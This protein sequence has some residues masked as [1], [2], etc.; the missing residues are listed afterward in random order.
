MRKYTLKQI[1]DF[2]R[3]GL[4][5][6]ISNY[7]NREMRDFMKAHRLEK[8]GY[9]AGINGINGGLLQDETSG[10]MYAITKRNAA[11]LTAF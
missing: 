8:V 5:S 11:L 4:A 9:S 7:S 3:L 10:E 1:R 6:D 2:V